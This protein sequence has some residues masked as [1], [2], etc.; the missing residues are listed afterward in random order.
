MRFSR[1]VLW[2]SIAY[3]AKPSIAIIARRPLLTSL[4]RIVLVAG[5]SAPPLASPM[6][7][8]NGPPGNGWCTPL[9]KTNFITL[10]ASDRLTD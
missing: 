7:L 5:S 10:H 3:A 8:K 6:K 9:I 1:G 4:V 2:V